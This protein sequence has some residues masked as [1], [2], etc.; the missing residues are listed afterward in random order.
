M[1]VSWGYSE[2]VWYMEEKENIGKRCQAAMSLISKWKTK[3]YCQA[4]YYVPVSWKYNNMYD[5]HIL[6][7]NIVYSWIFSD[8]I[9]WFTRSYSNIYNVFNLLHIWNANL[10]TKSGSVL[11][12]CKSIPCTAEHVKMQLGVANCNKISLPVAVLL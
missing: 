11:S 6:K 1:F 4:R 9:E 2:K 8:T 5:S 3:I 7:K 12:F 10:A